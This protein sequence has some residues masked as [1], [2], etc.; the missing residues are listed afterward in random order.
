MQDNEPRYVAI[1]NKRLVSI[2]YVR[3]HFLWAILAA[4]QTSETMQRGI[5]SVA[6]QL[7]RTLTFHKC[8][9]SAR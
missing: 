7:Q 8:T 4:T 6:W 9:S 3:P 1:P 2:A 5:F